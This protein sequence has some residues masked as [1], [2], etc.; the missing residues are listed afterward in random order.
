MPLQARRVSCACR[1]KPV[2]ADIFKAPPLLLRI[3]PQHQLLSCKAGQSHNLADHSYAICRAQRD[4]RSKPSSIIWCG[5]VGSRS[6]S[7]ASGYHC[8]G[9][10]FD[11]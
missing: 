6:I 4:M 11:V 3:P 1:S 2:R 7:E 9:Q 8:A 10:H 5:L